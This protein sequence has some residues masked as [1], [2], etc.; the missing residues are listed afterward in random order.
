VSADL[1]RDLASLRIERSE[2][3]EPR[4]KSRWPLWL[5]VTA[6]VVIAVGLLGSW[7]MTKLTR[8]TVRIGEVVT[9]TPAQADVKL[10][11]TGYVVPLRKAT[12]ASKLVAR[13]ATIK[14]SEGQDVK[15]G[16]VLAEL[17]ADDVRAGVAEARAAFKTAEARV[18]AA[19]ASL[20]ESK[21]QLGREK[22]LFAS[23]ASSQA[24]LDASQS[25]HEVAQANLEAAEADVATARARWDNA[26]SSLRNA[27]IVAPFAGRITKKLSEVGEVPGSIVGGVGGVVELVDFS[28]LVVEVDVSEGRIAQVQL[29]GPAEISLDAYPTRRLRGQVSEI[30]PTVDRQKATVLTRVKFMD[31]IEGVLP[32]MAARVMLLGKEISEESLKEPAKVVVPVSAV[33]ERSGAT[34]VFTVSEG[35]VRLT[36]VTVGAVLG[37]SR[38]ITSG[39]APGTKIVVDPPAS[40]SDGDAIKEKV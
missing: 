11:A 24:A 40:L 2:P 12:V 37:E 18:S 30:R 1:S 23:A 19:R 27:S 31:S 29:G 7:V 3:Q 28:S 13:V 5:G 32:Q 34:F 15:E 8:P 25:R 39:P 38:E 20:N 17:E 4:Q 33:V 10:M 16:Q 26:E 9:I 21:L 36:Q 35:K 14:V 22:A 6:A